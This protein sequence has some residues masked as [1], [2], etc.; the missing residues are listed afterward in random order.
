M[1]IHFWL[2]IHQISSTFHQVIDFINDALFH[3]LHHGCPVHEFELIIAHKHLSFRNLAFGIRMC[4]P[5]ISHRHAKSQRFELL[6]E[7][8]YLLLHLL[9]LNINTQ[10]QH[11]ILVIPV[12][13][14]IRE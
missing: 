7:I 4:T 2:Q 13:P 3:A 12:N 10:N 6:L 5:A 11:F 9:P 1:N 8:F 14:V